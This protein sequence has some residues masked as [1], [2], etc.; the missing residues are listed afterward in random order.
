MAR[1]RFGGVADYV[2]SAGVDNAATLQPNTNITCWNMVSG[3][4]QYTDLTKVDGET[5]LGALTTDSVGAVPEFFGPDGV[6][7]LYLDANGGSGPRRATIATDLGTDVTTLRTD[8]NAH[9]SAVNPHGTAY[10]DLVGVYAP[11]VADLL[12]QNP[13]HAAHR[14]SGAQYPEHT[15]VA[16]ESALAA[17]AQA[18]EVSAH[19][20]ADDVLVC[21]HD[22]TLSRVTGA[23][24][25]VRDYTYAA[26]SNLV[27]VKTQGL[28]G[29]GW[30][31]QPIPKLR[32]VLDRLYGR[33]VI[34]LEAKSNESIAPT[35]ALLEAQFPSAPD[36][37]VWKGY[38]TNTTFAEMRSRGFTTWGYMD[39]GTTDAQLDAVDMNVDIWGV[40]FA[41][42]D[43]RIAAV[44]GRGKPVMC[45]EVHRRSDAS[46]LTGLGVQGLM[47]AEYQYVT[48]AA[49]L[50]TVD[51]WATR[52]KAPGNS[53]LV[54]YDASYALQYGTDGDVFVD[55]V[56]NDSV[57]L[58]SMSPTAA[59]GYTISFEMKWDT[60]P[61]ASLH[62]DFVFADTADT[63]Y[64]FGAADNTSGGY[65]FVFRGNGD[66]QLYR[67]DPN[68]AS[69]VSLGSLATVQ[70]VAGQWMT[71]TIEVGP[72]FITVTRTDI[73]PDIQ[74]VA[75]DTTY[76][77]GYLQLSQGSVNSLACVP[78]WRNLSVTTP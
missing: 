71:F 39:A 27:K 69:G 78:H 37:I 68:V 29:D 8:L 57:L 3:G 60:L 41:M 43:T 35:M 21:F 19:I 59:S 30:E 28:L 51:D 2:I 74:F 47:C 31:D 20:T 73:E 56:T 75:D 55:R 72:E 15:M 77:G 44:V 49:A 63:R 23:T 50:N 54:G 45:W 13:F 34:F 12:S 7:V 6:A 33:C 14:G 46:R 10:A 67:H 42:S 26:L 40:P 61:A 17:G 58:G 5:P 76:R 70:P 64:Q 25:S 65:H 62:S 53:G 1:H 66:M 9:T 38:F 52:I 32:D 4:T 48:G 11:T 18:I 16:Y 22:T 24:G 36:S